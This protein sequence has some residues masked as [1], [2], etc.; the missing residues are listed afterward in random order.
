MYD[1]NIGADLTTMVD[2][3][4]YEHAKATG[5]LPLYTSCCPSWVNFAETRLESVLPKVSTA[6]SCV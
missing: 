1:V 2:F 3:K 5:N 4:E 6:K